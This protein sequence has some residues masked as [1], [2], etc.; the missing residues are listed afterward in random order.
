[1]KQI[2]AEQFL[3]YSSGAA[4]I[5]AEIECDTAEDLPAADHFNDRI[6]SMGSIAWVINSGEFYGL[7]S[8]GEWVLQNGGT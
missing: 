1:M 2:R 7:N 5:R 3:Y 4:V 8:S 6:L